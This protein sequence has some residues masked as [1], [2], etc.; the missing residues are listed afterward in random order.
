MFV[1]FFLT[2]KYFVLDLKVK[3]ILPNYLIFFTEQC[4]N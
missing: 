2:F 4:P 1:L 3:V